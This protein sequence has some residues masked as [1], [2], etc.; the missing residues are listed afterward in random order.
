MVN[1]KNAESFNEY[2]ALSFAMEFHTTK[3]KQNFLPILDGFPQRLLQ[4]L[5]KPHTRNSSNSSYILHV[6]S[7]GSSA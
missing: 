3:C 6:Q 5:A 2:F 1:M 7:D 4:G